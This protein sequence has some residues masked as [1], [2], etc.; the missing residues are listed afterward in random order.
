MPGR[1]IF[2][3]RHPAELAEHRIAVEN[4]A[5]L[6]VRR[7]MALDKECILPGVQ[8]ARDILC[9]LLQG[10]PPQVSRVLAHRNSVHVRH[11][12]KAVK[13]ISALS[14][15]LHRPQII[16][17]MQVPGWLNP[18]QHHFFML[19]VLIQLICSLSLSLCRINIIIY[20]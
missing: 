12:I 10:P 3:L 7:D 8:A 6:G 5:Q 17:E 1:L 11:E 2:E 15:L 16:A 13:A 14:P 4:P 18:G 19:T 9:E 20:I